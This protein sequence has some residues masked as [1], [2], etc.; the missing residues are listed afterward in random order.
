MLKT[1]AVAEGA[2]SPASV[3]AEATASVV[4]ENESTALATS[5]VL[6]GCTAGNRPYPR[7]IDTVLKAFDVDPMSEENLSESF[8][9]QGR[10]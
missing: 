3:C 6:P 1:S 7:E 4:A 2:V 5:N 9:V 10:T 8:G